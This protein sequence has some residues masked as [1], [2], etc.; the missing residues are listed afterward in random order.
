MS[1][2]TG[3]RNC[4]SGADGAADKPTVLCRD[5][6]PGA[7]QR[8]KV[9]AACCLQ[10]VCL[11]AAWSSRPQHLMGH[12]QL[13]CLADQGRTETRRSIQTEARGLTQEA[14]GRH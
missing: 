2:L 11:V 5:L 8:G 12:P 1:I 9:D 4:L 7:W 13:C 6:C 3:H 10:T 14:Q